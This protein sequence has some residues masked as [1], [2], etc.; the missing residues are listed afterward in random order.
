MNEM[1]VPSGSWAEMNSARQTKYNL[2]L[3]VGVASVVASVVVV[4]T[5][6]H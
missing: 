3:L 6:L 2:H 1:P 4:S 5:M